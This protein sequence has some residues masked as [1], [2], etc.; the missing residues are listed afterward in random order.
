MYLYNNDV[1]LAQHT[2]CPVMMTIVFSNEVDRRSNRALGSL[3]SYY[4]Y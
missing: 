2:L 1:Q 4:Q 3:L